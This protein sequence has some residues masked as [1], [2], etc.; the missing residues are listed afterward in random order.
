MNF[1]SLFRVLTTA[2][3]IMISYNQ[4][5]AK[6]AEILRC[7]GPT[8]ALRGTNVILECPGT[9]GRKIAVQMLPV[10]ADK[11]LRSDLCTRAGDQVYIFNSDVI[12]GPVCLFLAVVVNDEPVTTIFSFEYVDHVDPIPQ[13]DPVNPY[14]SPSPA[15]KSTVTPIIEIMR[16]SDVSTKRSDAIVIA[17]YFGISLP[18]RVRDSNAVHSTS[19]FRYVNQQLGSSE[20]GPFNFSSKYPRLGKE[21]DDVFSKA[22]GLTNRNLDEPDN[23]LR[24]IILEHCNGLAWALIEGSNSR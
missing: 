23:S 8:Q 16:S 5:P 13:P 9:A 20:L 6:P 21:V 7:V 2:I 15:V 17:R 10:G 4:S 12:K 18:A 14:P 22:L 11:F 19:E 3:S 1:Q 24:S